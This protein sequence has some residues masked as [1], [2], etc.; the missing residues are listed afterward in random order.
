MT[1]SKAKFCH[2][3][4][5]SFQA[6]LIR[7]FNFDIT[8]SDA[9]KGAY[10]L[11]RQLQVRG[12]T[13]QQRTS[14][15]R[16]PRG[17]PTH[18]T[19]TATTASTIDGDSGHS[20]QFRH[21]SPRYTSPPSRRPYGP[22]AHDGPSSPSTSAACPS[23]SSPPSRWTNASSRKC[24]NGPYDCRST[25]SHGPDAWTNARTTARP[26]AVSQLSSSRSSRL[27]DG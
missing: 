15:C 27:F 17:P 24:A 14:K 4:T 11:Q 19:A 26:N 2:N 8:G 5:Q 12:R 20:Y 6:N 18:A 7:N 25:P 10:H 3:R 16:T 9:S 21:K 13:S 1:A 22:K 23:C